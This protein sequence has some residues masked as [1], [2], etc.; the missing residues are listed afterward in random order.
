MQ[1]KIYII[2]LITLSIKLHS[3]FVGGH[4]SGHA[5]E[6]LVSENESNHGSAKSGYNLNTLYADNYYTLGNSKSGYGSYTFLENIINTIGSSNS[7]YSS[8]LINS[9]ALYAIGGASGGYRTAVLNTAS[10]AFKGGESSGYKKTNQ[11]RDFIWTGSIGT[12]WNIEENWNINAIPRIRNN[13]II[14]AGL[15]NYPKLNSGLFTIGQ[16]KNEGLYFCKSIF[17]EEGASITLRVNNFLENYN[18]IVID[19]ELQVLSEI[20]PSILNGSHGSIMINTGG[21]LSW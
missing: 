19:G 14:P 6:I 12:G 13:V 10:F 16:N 11:I 21:I 8:N 18:S 15:V 2:L 1:R 20:N 3:Q 7:G 9:N 17:I 4:G 5:E